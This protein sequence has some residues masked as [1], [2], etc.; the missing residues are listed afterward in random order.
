[1]LLYLLLQCGVD[2]GA[3]AAALPSPI[4]PATVERL[5]SSGLRRNFNRMPPPLDLNSRAAP[6]SRRRLSN[7]EDAA[8]M[9]QTENAFFCDATVTVPGFG[10]Q[11]CGAIVAYLSGPAAQH[12]TFWM[13]ECCKFDCGTC[14]GRTHG[15]TTSGACEKGAQ[16]SP[17]TG[18]PKS[19]WCQ[20][21]IA[22]RPRSAANI[23]TWFELHGECQTCNLNSSVFVERDHIMRLRR[24]L[25]TGGDAILSAQ[26]K[27]T[28]FVVLGTLELSHL[29]LRE[30]QANFA[31]AFPRNWPFSMQGERVIDKP[32]LPRV[33]PECLPAADGQKPHDDDNCYALASNMLIF[34][35]NGSKDKTPIRLSHGGAVHISR[36]FQNVTLDTVTI[37]DSHASGHGGGIFVDG[38]KEG[39][40]AGRLV[41]GGRSRIRG[42]TAAFGGGIATAGAAR[43][44]I[45]GGCDIDI[46][47]N[48]AVFEFEENHM[49]KETYNGY[50]NIAGEGGGIHFGSSH[51]GESQRGN[52][53]DYCRPFDDR[54]ENQPHMFVS[55]AGT[56]LT[57][58]KNKA[59]YAAGIIMWG[60]INITDGARMHVVQN[61]A[62]GIA[63]GIKMRGEGND[64]DGDPGI[65][66]RIFVSGRGSTLSLA[67]NSAVVA[68]GLWM[69]DQLL[70]G[71]K[72]RVENGATLEFVEN[73]AVKSP[74]FML[75]LIDK[76]DMPNVGAGAMLSG[77]ETLITG[78]GSRVLFV[79]NRGPVGTA[80]DPG[81]SLGSGAILFGKASLLIR[82][83]AELILRANVATSAG[84]LAVASQGTRLVVS[85][86]NS[87][88]FARDNVAT[89][90]M[91]GAIVATDGGAIRVGG[92]AS[93]E[94]LNNT[95]RVGGA[96]GLDLDSS[97]VA[98]AG[99]GG[100]FLA[101]NNS[102]TG[103]LGGGAVALA[104]GA[105]FRIMIPSKFENN[106]AFS[107]PGGAINQMFDPINSLSGAGECVNVTLETRTF[108]VPVRDNLDGKITTK[109]P[110]HL[111]TDP[112]LIGHDKADKI[113]GDEYV[114][115]PISKTYVWTDSDFA[116]KRS[117]WCVA[118]GRYLFAVTPVDTDKPW[119]FSGNLND[120]APTFGAS[121]AYLEVSRPFA[122]VPPL[123]HSK[124]AGIDAYKDRSQNTDGAKDPTPSR[125]H[126]TLLYTDR[127]A[128]ESKLFEFLHVPCSEMGVNLVG[129]IFKKNSAVTGGALA[130][131]GRQNAVFTLANSSFV[132]NSAV[133][134]GGAVH[135]QGVN[136][137]AIFRN[138][139]FVG[140]RCTKGSG[141]AV[142]IE[143]QAGAH[144]INAV[145]LEN[146]AAEDGGFLFGKSASTLLLQDMIIEKNVA[147]KGGGGGCAVFSSPLAL[148]QVSLAKCSAG[149]RGGGGI[150]LDEGAEAH[151]LGVEMD[152]NESS[153]SGGHLRVAASKAIFHGEGATLSWPSVEPIFDEPVL[154]GTPQ[155]A[156]FVE[157]GEKMKKGGANKGC[158]SHPEFEDISTADECS[159]AALMLFQTTAEEAP[160]LDF[161]ANLLPRMIQVRGKFIEQRAKY[162]ISYPVGRLN[163]DLDTVV[164]RG[165][166]NFFFVDS[167]QMAAKLAFFPRDPE[168]TVKQ[169]GSCS[170]WT[171]CLCRR[172]R[173]QGGSQDGGQEDSQEQRQQHVGYDRGRP[174]MLRRG[175]AK[176]SGGSI[177][178]GFAQSEIVRG[179]DQ[180]HSS[181]QGC[182][183]PF[184][185]ASGAQAR[186]ACWGKG[187]S[188][189]M[190]T[191]IENSSSV[192]EGG[193]ISATLCDVNLHEVRFVGNTAMGGKGGGAV[194]LG[195][196]ASLT[197]TGA[198][199]FSEN[200][201][202][203][204]NGGAILCDR[205]KLLS[206]SGG[207]VSFVKNLAQ[208]F[209][210]AISMQ[211]AEQAAHSTGSKFQGNIALEN[212]GGAFFGL[213]TAQA[214]GNWTSRGDVFRGNKADQGSG[215]A[216]SLVSTVFGWEDDSVCEENRAEQGGGGCVMWDAATTGATNSSEWAKMAPTISIPANMKPNTTNKARFGAY[217]ATPP[218]LLEL[219]SHSATVASSDFTTASGTEEGRYLRPAPRLTLLDFYGTKVMGEASTKDTNVRVPFWSE[220]R[221][222]GGS[223]ETFGAGTADTQPDGV[224][225][226]DSLGLRAP[227]GSG[228]YK[229]TFEASIGTHRRIEMREGSTLDVMVE[230]CPQNKQPDSEDAKLCEVCPVG[231]SKN[232]RAKTGT[233]SDDSCV[234]ARQF[235]SPLLN[236][237]ECRPCEKGAVCAAEGVTTVS[238]VPVPGHWR[239]NATTLVFTNCSLGFAGMPGGLPWKLAMDRCWP[240]DD[241]VNE[242]VN[243]SNRE[244][245]KCSAGFAGPLC[246]HCSDGFTAS[247]LTC[248]PCQ[249]GSSLGNVMAVIIP[250]YVV[251]FMFFVFLFIRAG[252]QK[253]KNKKNK[254]KRQE[255]DA[256]SLQTS[257]AAMRYAGDAVQI[258]RV[259]AQSKTN[260]TSRSDG[261]LLYD[262][263]KLFY[264]YCQI[265]S[266]FTVV[267]VD[268]PW[269]TLLADFSVSLNFVNLDLDLAVA[270][271]TFALPYLHQFAV[272]GATPAV[273]MAMLSLARGAAYM[274]KKDAEHRQGQRELFFKLSTSLLL[275][276][277]PGIAVKCFSIFKCISVPGLEASDAAGLHSGLVLQAQWDIECWS[278]RHSPFVIL[279]IV[280]IVLWVVGIPVAVFLFLR[281][282]RR[283]LYDQSHP[284][285][286][287]VIH[288]A[289][290]LYLQ[291]EERYWYWE[292]VIILKKCMLTGAM[293]IIAAGSSA[294][295]IIAM[296]VVLTYTLAAIYAKPFEGE[297]DDVLSSLTSIQLFLTLLGGLA[298]FTDDRNNPTYDSEYM[299]V[300]LCAVNA[301]G[302]V[303][304]ALSLV[305]LHPKIRR[306]VNTHEE[307]RSAQQTEKGGG[308]KVSPHP[309]GK[310]SAGGDKATTAT[311][312]T[313]GYSSADLK[314]LRGWDNKE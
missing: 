137:G 192:L 204:G 120:Q 41:F 248:V 114:K 6:S 112:G 198:S 175:K 254:K 10:Q 33:G 211:N 267:F 3:E 314:S 279:S 157:D 65:G 68:G 172:R 239:A 142:A 97:F 148:D 307:T 229:L 188:I 69:K 183:S 289:G 116:N 128:D 285:H 223:I 182:Q 218:V 196:A 80:D 284:R 27:F 113:N 72:L 130:A 118:C 110:S 86:Q 232:E 288:E 58:G 208:H 176:V 83:G 141:G 189:G 46:S 227:P 5:V 96:L 9:C 99:K 195:T 283:A 13:Q 186:S 260:D 214:P 305:M 145:A 156:I 124:Q 304:F 81:E 103:P 180:D 159:A 281:M 26:K 125:R 50:G 140:N 39:V 294:Q 62:T 246:M 262:R 42:C 236:G 278:D 111:K 24:K 35:N 93:V 55:G 269:P 203:G 298:M 299:G 313:T 202:L 23:G 71:A 155:Y 187:V 247:G 238:M 14:S 162:N 139:K 266:S 171:R 153:E 91:G 43:I 181:E 19:D 51:R 225:V 163:P 123:R 21:Q 240:A 265:F 226:F 30:G 256:R 17:A 280:Y 59:L 2:R 60:R 292:I 102:A 287:E 235:Y 44:E 136:S 224:A 237:S 243:M 109:P 300:A 135:I 168:S 53:A 296:L 4:D 201:A 28:H 132:G 77:G 40:D 230:W 32:L 22:G 174:N 286:K 169:G 100:F 64:R 25:S 45:M 94:F 134:R 273:L 184:M 31:V 129:A 38:G 117:D 47:E 67:Q 95:A 122:Q 274:L 200:K 160:E 150:L 179:E 158:D 57:L 222:G 215:G 257:N 193:A 144:I 310:G 308:T 75:D 303:A 89:K 177:F 263:V 173:G 194:A 15:S 231:K 82:D 206:L 73:V 185:P 18:P 272:H 233:M 79:G 92:G 20:S 270:S 221:D 54:T 197:V 255:G 146:V 61:T 151:L 291:Y 78:A 147:S 11:E 108:Q 7:A 66:A 49:Y 191:T 52:G 166:F 306:M 8:A 199:S 311:K 74:A 242:T 228:P 207:R 178:C 282:H 213:G 268:C 119:F 210:G 295:L 258:E 205:C 115:D 293:T 244:L 217:L 152:E 16:C 312:S 245:R 261:Q 264:G 48:E 170:R 190:G 107:G 241:V 70:D 1:M 12:K 234:C 104:A 251:V 85:G 161:E 105:S 301:V 37:E 212:D 253:N 29:I 133:F 34:Q 138:I 290:N 63:G 76:A 90:Q 88:L 250:V 275:L 219:E 209:G 167:D 165:C 121:F 126:R 98:A 276:M 249:D 149:A 309:P 259:A 84:G 106:R 271:C 252:E 154:L 220:V 131:S 56:Q 127:V 143:G 101:A 36:V 297:S 87:R 277:Y 216:I 302:F 164:P